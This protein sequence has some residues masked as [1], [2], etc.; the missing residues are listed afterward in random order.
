VSTPRVSIVLVVH[1][2]Q[3]YLRDGVSSILGQSFAD[4]ELLAIDN[5]SRDHGP[6]ILD[7]LA[8]NDSRLKVRHLYQPVS[9]SE[10]RNIALDSATGEYVWFV[11]TTD[12]MPAKALAAVASRL[13]KTN[14]DVLLVDYAR[15]GSVGTPGPGPHQAVIQ[16]ASDAKTFALEDQ[17]AVAVTAPGAWDKLF[18]R[19]LLGKLGLRFAAGG[20]GELTVTYPALL[21]SDRISVLDEVCY[22]RREPAN[23][24]DEPLVHGG[25]FDVFARYDAAFRFADS[26]R[27]VPAARR[28]LL[29]GAMLRHLLS[30][31]ESL[32]EGRREE[33]FGR[34]SDSYRRHARGDEPPLAGRALRTKIRFVEQGSYG[35]FRGFSWAVGQRRSAPKRLE[36]T[37]SRGASIARARWRNALKAYYRSQL[38]RPID[39][40]LAVF[41]SY[42]YRGYSCNPRAIYERLGELAPWIRG[43]WVVNEEH[44]AGMPSDV[45][46]VLANSREYYR[47]IAG[48]KHFVNNVNFPNEVVK[49]EGTIHLHTHHGVPLKKMGL[50]LRD[51]PGTRSKAYFQRLLERCARWDYLVSPNAFSTVI[52]E[53][54]YPLPYETLEVG[55][56][57]NDVLVNAN[58]A[59]IERIRTKLGI[60][61]GQRAVLYAPTHREYLKGPPPT[62]DVDRL[63]NELGPDYVVMA[64]AHYFYENDERLQEPL[65]AGRHVLDVSGH[66]S[67]EE[68]CLAADVLVTDY[69]SIMFDYAVLDRPIVIHAPDWVV[70]RT[71]R[72]TTFDLLAEPPGIVATADDD[73]VEAFR[74]GAVW[75]EGAGELRAAFRARFCTLDDGHAAE[76]V[77]RRVFLSEEAAAPPGAVADRAQRAGIGA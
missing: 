75:G 76:R 37:R 6:A 3:A 28:R 39:P 15:G 22:L 20:F 9:L 12:L 63:G 70:Y 7:E 17:P 36:S 45:P 52:L 14:P 18:R 62:L 5:A 47:L 71:L 32:P 61:E 4:L 38:R 11:E 46:Y 67:V 25:P 72:G 31:L 35:T 2:E 43:V 68:L 16:D 56:P 24:V 33:F 49:R 44:W 77:I 57:R 59:E 69:S 50:D 40:D 26:D 58:D 21:A 41:A 64:R 1:G 60:A 73:V 19:E 51:A 55:Y 48:A 65:W 42:W 8:Q 27:S 30:I 54:A 34:M 13:E 53:R 23:A 74:S 66:S 10:A 29:P